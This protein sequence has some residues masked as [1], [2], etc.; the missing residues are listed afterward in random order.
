[1]LVSEP[2][3]VPAV[4][5]TVSSA[6]IVPGRM[7]V[8]DEPAVPVPEAEVPTA[9]SPHAATRVARRDPTSA[10][11]NATAAVVQRRG[12]QPASALYGGDLV[13]VNE[14]DVRAHALARSCAGGALAMRLAPCNAAMDCAMVARMSRSTR[15][16]GTDA[17]SGAGAPVGAVVIDRQS[18]AS[19]AMMAVAASGAAQG[20]LRFMSDEE[21][22]ASLAAVLERWSP[23]ED[24]WLF[25]YG[26][27][28]WNPTFAF[29][30]RR[31]ARLPGYQRRY[32]VWLPIGRGSPENPGLM[33]GLEAGGTCEGVAYRIAA[34]QV[35]AEL[36]LVWK[37]EMLTG[38]YL[39]RWVPVETDAGDFDAVSFVVDATH[40]RR[41]APD[42]DEAVVVRHLATAGGAFGTC[43]EYLERTVKELGALGLR[44]PYVERL[45]AQV[46]E[47][48]EQHGGG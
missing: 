45:W 15:A 5:P 48:R 10:R 12:M 9:S 44:D 46:L 35:R 40:E 30:E 23:H 11:R 17:G 13:A 47:Y 3:P 1:M 14:N 4:V 21:R 22:E 31:A 28:L 27:L 42:V 18:V 43:H 39:A 16:D 6:E 29:V 41:V 34:S 37:R 19:G 2:E 26:S 25:A 24:V 20:L 32:C 36:E 33:L 8:V 38:S 7:S